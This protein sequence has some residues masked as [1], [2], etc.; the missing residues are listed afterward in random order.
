MSNDRHPIL[1]LA[2][3]LAPEPYP[4]VLHLGRGPDVT[5]CGER[6]LTDSGEIRG[7]LVCTDVLERLKDAV[8][9]GFEVC[10]GCRDGLLEERLFAIGLAGIALRDA[11]PEKAIQALPPAQAAAVA[12]ALAVIELLYPRRE[13]L[14]LVPPLPPP[15]PEVA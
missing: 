4:L 13:G 11:F 9:L 7:E 3:A 5:Y 12:G 14:R 8:E 10:Q 1:H 15:P 6:R 2:P